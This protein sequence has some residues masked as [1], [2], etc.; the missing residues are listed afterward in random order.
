MNY[1]NGGM[2]LR[3]WMT[4]GVPSR[5][6]KLLEIANRNATKRGDKPP[7]LSEPKDDREREERLATVWV[8]YLVE[9]GFAS[10]ACW[11]SSLN[12]EEILVPLPTSTDEFMQRYDQ[13]GYMKPNPQT[14]HDLDVLTH[15]PLPDPF[16]L[17]VKSSI[18]LGRVARWIYN[19]RQ[20]VVCPGDELAG[21]SQPSFAKLIDDIA[22]FET[23][24]PGSLKNIYRLVDSGAVNTFT[25]ELLSVHIFPKLAI[26]LLYEPFLDWDRPAANP[27]ALYATQRAF[28]GIVGLVH[29]IPSQ[30]DVTQLFTPLLAFS[31]FTV[32]RM[33][34]RFAFQANRDEQYAIAMRWRADLISINSVLQRYA[35]KHVVGNY[36][37]QYIANHVKMH[38]EGRK[39]IDCS[40]DCHP[41]ATNTSTMNSPSGTPDGEMGTRSSAA[42]VSGATSNSPMVSSS[43]GRTPESVEAVDA[44]TQASSSSGSSHHH[45]H[46]H[47]TPDYMQQTLGQPSDQGFDPSLLEFLDPTAA[48]QV[49]AALAAANG[50]IPEGP[51]SPLSQLLAGLGSNNMNGLGSPGSA[52]GVVNLMGGD[53][54][55][56]SFSGQFNN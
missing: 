24:L 49:Q 27:T 46:H 10:N 21:M 13:T 38:E 1:L 22:A 15:H 44:A 28:E 29:L 18:L 26:M 9:S 31:M 4:G 17:V 7:I 53:I 42:S 56:W 16:V 36:L 52:N 48:A 35:A 20:R 11:S 37:Q 6:I 3:G 5:L 43:L 47:L 39:E 50:K 14:A 30:L 33:V 40:H 51:Q 12:V 41:R 25:S 23:H 54:S 8:A 32:G 34:S 19:W 55:G 2:G 45:H